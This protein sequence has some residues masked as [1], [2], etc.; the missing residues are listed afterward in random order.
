MIGY[1]ED[2]VLEAGK[3][4][5]QAIRLRKRLRAGGALTWCEADEVGRYSLNDLINNLSAISLNPAEGEAQ[6]PIIKYLR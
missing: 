3:L 5:V 6:I 1:D 2:T 4:L